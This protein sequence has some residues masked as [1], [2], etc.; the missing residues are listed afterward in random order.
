MWF[1]G[2]AAL[3]L[4][5]VSTAAAAEFAVT[6]GGDDGPGTLREAMRQALASADESAIVRIDE[7]V[8]VVTLTTGTLPVVERSLYIDGRDATIRRDAE[9]PPFRIFHGRT[10]DADL[11]LQD[12]TL[13]NGGGEGIA[14]G[15]IYMQDTVSGRSSL[16]LSNVTIRACHGAVGGAIGAWRTDLHLFECVIENNRAEAAGGGIYHRLYGQLTISNSTIRNNVAAN[17]SGGGILVISNG[18]GELTMNVVAST[19]SGNRALGETAQGGGIHHQNPIANDSVRTLSLKRCTVSG[20]VSEGD[21]GGIANVAN[22]TF[23]NYGRSETA[24]VLDDCTVTD[25]EAT[26]AGGGVF[27]QAI[28]PNEDDGTVTL[29]GSIVAGNRAA[30]GPDLG[31][32]GTTAVLISR[33]GNLVGSTS[34][35]ED[36]F[37]KTPAD[38]RDLLGDTSAPLDPML[39]PLAGNGGPTE[40]HRPLDGSPVIDAHDVV[41]EFSRDQ[42]GFGFRR[43]SGEMKDIGAVEVQQENPAESLKVGLNFRKPGK[44]SMKLKFRLRLDEDFDPDG[45]RLRIVIGQKAFATFDARGRAK[46]EEGTFRLK[47]SRDGEWILKVKLAKGD[48]GENLARYGLTDGDVEER[49]AFLPF[50][51]NVGEHD[52]EGHFEIDYRAKEGRRGSGKSRR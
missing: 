24:L 35:V 21:G 28:N 31:R 43:V 38:S 10:T 18:F 9:A 46:N 7:S 3:L 15:G 19:I 30:E 33:G 2:A 25:N 4:L 20:N 40:T 36:F 16:Q 29:K 34:G 37:L 52:F 27:V 17:G 41:T 12:L 51:V 26:G 45:Q 5:M 39:G 49:R 44:D 1:A 11:R 14:G 32:S 22:A 13:E 6:D 47:R 8:R 42:R 50:E 48:R 23:R